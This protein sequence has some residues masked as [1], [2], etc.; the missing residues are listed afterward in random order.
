MASKAC[1]ELILNPNSSGA[2][3][4]IGPGKHFG[5]EL[6]KRFAAEDIPVVALATSLSS[7]ERLR[8]QLSDTDVSFDHEICDVRDERDLTLKL[9]RIKAKYGHISCLIYNPKISIK[10]CG[11]GTTTSDLSE[12]LNVNVIGALTVIQAA[13]ELMEP[14]SGA[15]I[16]L[17]GGGFKDKPDINRFSLS[18]GKS[19][20]HGLA[21]SL[22]R[23][24][25]RR[26]IHLKTI[27]I[28]GY[29]RQGSTL[30]PSDVA[31][32]FWAAHKNNT[33]SVFKISEKEASDQL[34]LFFG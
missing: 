10:S 20:L 33:K 9:H 18:V 34:Q 16:I 19:G 31:E 23:P 22:A 4:L 3:V 12:S 5:S 8:S 24:V 6:I 15:S 26:G 27:V 11:L 29:V 30:Q 25:A 2:M 28:D 32:A 14:Y 7:V 1:E 21:R 17:T 13:V